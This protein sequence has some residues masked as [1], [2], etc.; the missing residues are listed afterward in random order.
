MLP[1]RSLH[2][3][4]TRMQYSMPLLYLLLLMV[5]GMLALAAIFDSFRLRPSKPSYLALMAA[6][7]P[8]GLMLLLFYSLAFHL[9]HYLGAWPTS[10][11]DSGF[12]PTLRTH[13]AIAEY[14]FLAFL[15]VTVLVW[16]LTY[17]L[18]VAIRRWRGLRYYLGIYALASLVCCGATWFAPS[19]FW[20]WWWD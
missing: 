10:I 2:S 20:N 9:H 17:I 1:G 13:E 16:P 14:Y 12:P 3:T 15:L 19:Q 11:G 18:S 8:A 7:L 5:V 6:I 4:R